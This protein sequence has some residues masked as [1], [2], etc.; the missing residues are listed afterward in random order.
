VPKE[1]EDGKRGLLPLRGTDSRI[2]VTQV[3]RTKDRNAGSPDSLIRLPK[4]QED[5]KRRLLRRRRT[6][7]RIGVTQVSRT[8]DRIAGSPDS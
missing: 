7:S 8:K 3:S 1:Q 2:G 5:G 4:E 6:N